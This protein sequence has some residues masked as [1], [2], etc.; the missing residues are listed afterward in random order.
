M[1]CCRLIGA[2]RTVRRPR[3]LGSGVN[4]SHQGSDS[5]NMFSSTNRD[6]KK[7]FCQLPAAATDQA[8]IAVVRQFVLNDL[9]Q[10]AAV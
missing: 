7:L 4:A 1:Q 3:A 9:Q 5:L 8:F 6:V 2:P 10:Y